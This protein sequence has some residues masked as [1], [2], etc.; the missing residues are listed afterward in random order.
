LTSDEIDSAETFPRHER[1]RLA[2]LVPAFV[3]EYA[4]RDIAKPL[5]VSEFRLLE[6]LPEQLSGTLPTI[7]EI[8]A[9]FAHP[10][11]TST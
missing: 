10:E 5:G 9:E 8:E 7:A 2:K 1:V 4:L 6:K 3:A 11:S